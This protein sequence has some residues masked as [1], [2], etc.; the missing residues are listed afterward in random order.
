MLTLC[1]IF[2]DNYLYPFL[3]SIYSASLNSDS[4]FDL[5]VGD[6]GWNL[7][8]LSK[9]I[10]EETCK[11]LKISLTWLPMDLD[12]SYSRTFVHVVPLAIGRIFFMDLLR[13]P[14]VYVDVDVLFLPGWQK[15]LQNSRFPLGV[16]AKVVLGDINWVRETNLI[17][18]SQGK[19]PN[20]AMSIDPDS[21]FNAGLMIV[22]PLRWQA[23]GA[24]KKWKDI[25][26]TDFESL[27]MWMLDQ[28]ILNYVL[29]GKTEAL[30][31]NH[32][33]QVQWAPDSSTFK[34]FRPDESTPPNI[35][36]FVGSAK[37]WNYS[38]VKRESVF[39]RVID[40]FSKKPGEVQHSTY[41]WL[42]QYWWYENLFWEWSN[43]QDSQ[44]LDV[45][46]SIHSNLEMRD[47]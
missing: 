11:I 38:I 4:S 26:F 22:D 42:I 19:V 13:S 40:Y 17:I 27:G 2:D 44:Y 15:T 39:S 16:I 12:S 46:K 3:M 28:D 33:Y 18:E 9:E 30:S 43:E 14:F 35:L 31:S 34:S 7:N 24:P 5:I 23:S 1:M 47:F 41:F 25:Y 32:N 36:H 8:H 6:T 10:I 37:P 21:Y 20:Q 29:K 45:L